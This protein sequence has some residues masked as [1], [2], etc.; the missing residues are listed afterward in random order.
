MNLYFEYGDGTVTHTEI[1]AG[2]TIHLRDEVTG[3]FFAVPTTGL[4]GVALGEPAATGMPEPADPEEVRAEVQAR[5]EESQADRKEWEASFYPPVEE[6]PPQDVLL[7]EGDEID[8]PPAH[9]I[10]AS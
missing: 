8:F 4:V 2:Q 9:K 7:A 3:E 6:E 10:P 1:G 5:I